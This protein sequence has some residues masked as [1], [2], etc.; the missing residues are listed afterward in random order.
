M[1][2]MAASSS[3]G[4]QGCSSRCRRENNEVILRSYAFLALSREEYLSLLESIIPS[5]SVR[6]C[7]LSEGISAFVLGLIVWGAP[8][9]LY[10]K[11][12]ML[13]LLASRENLANR[14]LDILGNRHIYRCGDGQLAMRVRRLIERSFQFQYRQMRRAIKAL[15]ESGGAVFNLT[16]KQY[17]GE[18]LGEEDS[19]GT[20]FPSVQKACE[21][22][23]RDREECGFDEGAAA[24]YELEKWVPEG[25]GDLAVS[26]R[27][28]FIGTTPV[29]YDECESRRDKGRLAL[30]GSGAPT[31]YLNI[32]LRC[33]TGDLVAIDCLPFA[34]V[35]PALI[36]E[37]AGAEMAFDGSYPTMLSRDQRGYWH[38]SSLKTGCF[39][40]DGIGDTLPLS[41]CYRL[42]PY[43][44]PLEEDE[45]ILCAV[46][47]W[48]QSDPKRARALWKA[49]NQSG[50]GEMTPDDILGLL[51]MAERLIA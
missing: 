6:G 29:F 36:L 10:E 14:L 3:D 49:G 38:I 12:E 47:H 28:T 9:S 20:P 11:A 41:P 16:K 8:L 31:G 1:V 50:K 40:N 46:Q 43:D 30:P 39:S 21:C 44:A 25:D 13:G 48:L 26:Y 32:P 2:S 45:E 18:L 51:K 5:E 15:E 22:I 4:L 7:L 33:N 24:W 19:R 27:Y 17:E 42:R 23:N 35:K 37:E 34:P